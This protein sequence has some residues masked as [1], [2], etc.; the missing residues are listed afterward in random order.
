MNRTQVSAVP[1]EPSFS[2]RPCLASTESTVAEE[3]FYH[4]LCEGEGSIG[5]IYNAPSS[6]EQK[7]YKEFEGKRFKKLYHEELV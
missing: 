3:P 7:V 5:Q 1:N 6:D 2:T 4:T